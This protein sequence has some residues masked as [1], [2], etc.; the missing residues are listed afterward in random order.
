MVVAEMDRGEIGV[1]RLRDD[2]IRHEDA[3][4]ARVEPELAG[5]PGDGGEDENETQREPER[6]PRQVTPRLAD[7]GT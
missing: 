3:L 7:A 4:E 6:I 1:A 5:D 2:F